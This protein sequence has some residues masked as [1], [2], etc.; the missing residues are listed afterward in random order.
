MIDRAFNSQH[1]DLGRWEDVW[2][3]AGGLPATDSPPDDFSACKRS[4]D[5]P[6]MMSHA[7]AEVVGI[8]SKRFRRFVL[9]SARTKVVGVS[10]ARG[11][12][13]VDRLLGLSR[14]PESG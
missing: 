11:L 9:I 12:A 6:M 3:G 4:A 2:P 13:A 14:K 5:D 8:D 7:G 10:A 1:G